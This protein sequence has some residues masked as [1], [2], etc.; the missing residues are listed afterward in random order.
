MKI[1]QIIIIIAVLIIGILIGKVVFNT[2]KS[3]MSNKEVV[4]KHW[5]CSMHPKVDLPEFGDC[6][7]CGMDLISKAVN[8]DG[9]ISENAFKMTKN[10]M[11]LAN[12]ETFEVGGATTDNQKKSIA[13]SGQIKIN[14]KET[15]I[16]IAPFG[17]RIE[18]IYIKSS[19]EYVKTGKLIATIY[20]PELVSVQNELIEAVDIKEEQPELYK[21]IRNKMKLWKI[22]ET[23]IQTIENS[24][25]VVVNFNLYAD[26][27]G[28]V[29]DIY[30]EEGNYIAEGASLF[31]V[32]NLDEVWAE[33]DVYEQNIKSVHMGQII[34]MMLNAYPN[35]EIKSR[36]D[37][38]DPVLNTKTRTV[39]VRTTISNKNKKLK[40]GMFVNAIVYIDNKDTIKKQIIIPKSSVLWTGKRSIVYVKVKKNEPVFEIRRVKLGADLGGYYE[41]LSGLKSGERVVSNGTFTVDAAAQLSGKMSMMSTEND[42]VE[43]LEVDKRFLEKLNFV[44]KDYM[45]LSEALVNANSSKASESAKKIQKNLLKIPHELLRN[46]ETHDVWVNSSNTLSRYLNE[47]SAEND[48]EKKRLVFINLSKEMINIVKLFGVQ[49]TIYIVHCPMANENKG[50]DWISFENK[51][52]NPYFGDKMLHCGKVTQVIL[53][54]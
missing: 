29:T 26:V 25:K 5:T 12:I 21:S 49:D 23:Q 16:Q 38:I 48:L 19:G 44:Y 47:I 41:I 1:K 40:P 13:L 33:F 52:L 3:E 37:F 20:S 51:V 35:K 8:S 54:E 36:I 46:K 6:P 14:E 32:A 34:S 50:A 10:A 53:N 2:E 18:K 17:G 43:Q 11:A 28:Y 45:T 30:K 27:A 24:K 7:T 22:S 39:T 31:K 15:N 4:E 9:D 42:E